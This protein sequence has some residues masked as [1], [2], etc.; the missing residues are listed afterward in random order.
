MAA[1]LDAAEVPGVAY[2]AVGGPG[3]AAY[4]VEVRAEGP[5]AGLAVGDAGLDRASSCADR[6]GRDHSVHL[7]RNLRNQNLFLFVT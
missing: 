1:V 7:R 3:A 6:S 4:D 5:V 2:D